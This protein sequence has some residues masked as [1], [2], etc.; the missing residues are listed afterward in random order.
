M[1]KTQTRTS[2]ANTNK[3]E[4]NYFPFNKQYYNKITE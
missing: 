2:D 3:L 4:Q 1:H